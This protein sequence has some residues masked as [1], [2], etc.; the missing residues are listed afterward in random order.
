MCGIAGYVSLSGAVVDPGRAR[1]MIATLRHRG[2]DDVGVAVSGP[3]ALAAARLSILDV[4]GGHQPMAVDGGGVTVVQNGEIYNYLE[5]RD[6]LVR[7]GRAFRT[8]SDTEVVAAL[9]AELGDAAFERMRGMFAIA[10]WDA[11]RRRLVLAR[12]RV[13]KKPLYYMQTGDC[14]LFASEPK[15]LL[16]VLPRVPD[17]SMSALLEFLTFGYVAGDGAI[18]SGMS[19]LEPGTTLVLEPPNAPR[20]VRYWTWP[21]PSLMEIPE[22][23]YLERLGAELDEAV[24]IR[25][26]SD[27]P[28]GAFLSGG[29][30]SATVLALMARHSSRPVKTFSIG[31]GD[32]EYDELAAAR[33]TAGAFGADH[34]EWRI[35]PDCVKVAEKLAA[36]YDE[37]FADASAIPTLLRRGAREAA[38]DRLSH[39][40]RRRRALRR[41]PSVRAGAR[42]LDERG[43]PRDAR[44]GR[45]WRA[46]DADPRTRQGAA[47][48]PRA[49][50]RGVVRLAADGVPRLS[51][52]AD[53]HTGSDR[54][55]VASCRKTKPSRIC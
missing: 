47:R 11:P 14:F 19:R 9:Y 26:R 21:S 46:M 42:P 48:H 29:L 3:A 44:A 41:L 33:A 39:R 52:A 51:P 49:R 35:E 23:E 6:A 45:A 53:C 37:P 31:F 12:D 2:P 32:A 54:G 4:S 13:G 28:L 50:A 24:R 17:V 34:H 22:P 55:D 36:Y 27:V 5:L 10:I 40:R 8:S 38:R 18:F 20:V 43:K 15:A 1:E 16:A 25:L 7:G 30:D